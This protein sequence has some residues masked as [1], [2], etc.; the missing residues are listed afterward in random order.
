MSR[1]RTVILDAFVLAAFFCM[2]SFHAYAGDERSFYQDSKRGFYWGED[3]AK[4]EDKERIPESQKTVPKRTSLK[5]FTEE[6]LWRMDPDTFN[7]LRDAVTKRAIGDTSNEEYIGEYIRIVDISRKRAVAFAN[8]TQAYLMK[9]PQYNIAAALP[10][11]E[12]GRI[13]ASRERTREIAGKIA[14]SQDDFALVYFHQPGCGACEEQGRILEYFV[15]RYGWKIKPVDIAAS[16][17]AAQTFG[18][19][20]TPTPCWSYPGKT[21]SI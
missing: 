5:E 6:E 1:I 21:G 16:P 14:S 13:A 10:L 8:T 2:L 12:P 18:I 19:R 4:K 3:P 20:T 15:E 17:A 11:A 9:H 7:E